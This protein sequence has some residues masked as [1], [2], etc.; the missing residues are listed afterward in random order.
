ML[1]SRFRFHGHGSLKFLFHRGQTMRS[2][3]LA[4]RYAP[5]PRRVHSRCC[6]VIS[7]KVLKGSPGRNRVRRR[8][9]EFMRINWQQLRPGYDILVSVYDPTF[10]DM[11]YDDFMKQLTEALARAGLWQKDKA[12]P[13]N[14]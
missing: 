8:I 3:S 11:P 1:Q 5:N 12:K 14:E 2:R 4:V 7:R 9:Y 10:A 6:I 13:E